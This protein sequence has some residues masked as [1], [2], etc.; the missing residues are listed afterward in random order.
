MESIN[1]RLAKLGLFGSFKRSSTYDS[2]RDGC[3]DF[4]L[5]SMF[6]GNKEIMDAFAVVSKEARDIEPSYTTEENIILF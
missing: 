5:S 2:D 1:Y 6:L 4:F 3:S